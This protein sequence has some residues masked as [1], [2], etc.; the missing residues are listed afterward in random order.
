MLYILLVLIMRSNKKGK[1]VK[2]K[3]RR[4]KEKNYIDPFTG[5][6]YIDPFMGFKYDINVREQKVGDGIEELVKGI[7]YIYDKYKKRQEKKRLPDI[8]NVLQ[9]EIER[10][11]PPRGNLFEREYHLSLYYWLKQRFPNA[12]IEKQI[13]SSRPDIVIGHNIAIELKGPTTRQGLITIADKINRY[14]RYFEYIIVV[15][16]ALNVNKEFYNEWYNGIT[17]RYSNIIIINK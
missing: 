15:L 3:R 12:D 5:L 4:V 9:E 6:K 16:F 7:R 2:R 11:E 1:K 8:I 14:S 17:S 13:G 10:F